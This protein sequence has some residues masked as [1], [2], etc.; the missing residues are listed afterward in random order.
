MSVE[1]RNSYRETN[2]DLALGTAGARIAELIRRQS[3]ELTKSEQSSL[4]AYPDE[5]ILSQ[6]LSAA[7]TRIHPEKYHQHRS[8]D[9]E[10]VFDVAVKSGFVRPEIY[11]P[12][13]Q[14]EAKLGIHSA[15][16]AYE[17]IVEVILVP[18]AAGISNLKRLYH[19]LK[20]I[21]TG[22]VRT[23]HII[24]AAGQRELD[25]GEKT[26]VTQAGFHSGDTEYALCQ[27]AVSALLNLQ[28]TGISPIP[29]SYG[30]QE[31][32]AKHCQT[33]AT[34][35]VHSVTIDIIEAPYDPQRTLPD[36]RLATR[37]NTEET[38]IPI[39]R[40]LAGNGPIYVVSHDIWQPVQEIIAYRCFPDHVILGSGPQNLE[41]V[42]R[43]EQ[44]GTLRL[45]AAASVQ[46]EM[47][48]YLQELS[49]IHPLTCHQTIS[50]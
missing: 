31:F 45:H 26:R 50:N 3:A 11:Q 42:S 8:V 13:N 40:L 12:A 32:L 17:G 6:L 23:N 24:I 27:N 15:P 9:E 39:H 41:R 38:F 29:M 34:I 28:P 48:K 7:S 4:L 46:D 25:T 19:A 1:L 18:G 14:L 5:T 10:T 47:K 30:N 22:A 33:S 2:L 36:G 44:T 37:A 20:A 43:D 16:E 21:E 49:K 35:G